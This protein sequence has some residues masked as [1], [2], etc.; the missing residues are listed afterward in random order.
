MAAAGR[1]GERRGSDAGMETTPVKKKWERS[2]M[3][4]FLFLPLCLWTDGLNNEDRIGF[5]LDSAS[6]DLL[7]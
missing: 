1:V 6:T 7:F 5:L 4:C 3:I 2:G